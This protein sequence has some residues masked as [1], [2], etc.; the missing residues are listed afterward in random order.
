[1]VKKAR[2][3]II[4]SAVVAATTCGST[5]NAAPDASPDA[6]TNRDPKS[7]SALVDR[8]KL[9]V[10]VA[11]LVRLDRGDAYGM[12]MVPRDPDNRVL[13]VILES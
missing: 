13:R 12:V 5:L 4:V 10:R 1:M 7:Q 3:T 2:T 9:T 11:P 6:R 8:A